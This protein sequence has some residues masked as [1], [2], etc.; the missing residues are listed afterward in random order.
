MCFSFDC[1]FSSLISCSMTLW[2]VQWCAFCCCA[3]GYV[4]LQLSFVDVSLVY[5]QWI[6]NLSNGFPQVLVRWSQ[7]T[8]YPQDIGK[9]TGQTCWAFCT[10][11]AVNIFS[12]VMC[13]G[14]PIRRYA[15]TACFEL[16]LTWSAM[17]FSLPSTGLKKMLYPALWRLLF[18]CHLFFGQS[19]KT[20]SH[21]HHVF[22]RGWANFIKFITR[23]CV[24]FDRFRFDGCKIA[25]AVRRP[26]GWRSTTPRPSLTCWPVSQ[27]PVLR[28]TSWT[29]SIEVL[30]L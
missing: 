28:W 12:K 6:F 7:V 27:R 3:L 22:C 19:L 9:L 8:K 13:M 4:I 21:V 23:F 15:N 25:T 26:W 5:S 10:T 16:S 2:M 17:K 30:T 14:H 1:C 24:C 29:V 11:F 18:S 20:H